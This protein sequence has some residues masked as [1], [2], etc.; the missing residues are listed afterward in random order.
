MNNLSIQQLID[1]GDAW[2]LEGHVGRRCMAAIENGDAVLGPEPRIDFWGNR[3]P[4]RHEV[5]PGTL[6]SIEYANRLREERGD[7]P[8][9]IEED[10]S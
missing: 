4:S 6:G 5:T 10:K 2:K 9:S 3:V 7:E 8:L 1:S